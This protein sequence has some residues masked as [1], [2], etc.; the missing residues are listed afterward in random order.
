MSVWTPFINDLL[1]GRARN[2]HIFP[3]GQK[4]YF[5]LLPKEKISKYRVN[6]CKF[7]ILFVILQR[8]IVCALAR[9]RYSTSKLE[10]HNNDK[11]NF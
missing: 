9:A 11:E 10:N 4:R 3:C 6:I 2:S 5:L 8:G 1:R 7:G